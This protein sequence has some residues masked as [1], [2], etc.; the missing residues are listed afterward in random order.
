MHLTNTQPDKSMTVSCEIDMTSGNISD[1]NR[2]GLVN[3]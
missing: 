3:V 2:G 1:V